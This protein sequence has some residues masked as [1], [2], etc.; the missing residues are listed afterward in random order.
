MRIDVIQRAVSHHQLRRRLL[1]D[2]WYA[3]NIV[4][5]IAHQRFQLDEL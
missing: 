1:P 5:G 2:L 4:R 3:G